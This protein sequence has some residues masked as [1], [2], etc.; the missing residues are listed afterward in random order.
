MPVLRFDGLDDFLEFD[1][2]NQL[3]TLF[4]VLN[5]NPGNEGFCSW[6]TRLHTLSTQEQI[7]WSNLWSDVYVLNGLLQVNGNVMDGVST[8]YPS[9]NRDF[10][11]KNNRST[12]GIQF[13]KRPG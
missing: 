2:I 6:A 1:E 9:A 8:N 11:L 10:C 12:S 7:F 4:M 3:R 13:F 5:R